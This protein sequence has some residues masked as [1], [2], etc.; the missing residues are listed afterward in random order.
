[1]TDLAGFFAIAIVVIVTPGPDTA[2]TIRNSLLGGRTAGVAVEPV[3]LSPIH[4]MDRV[5][6][7]TLVLRGAN[8]TNCPVVE[9]EQMVDEI[10][11]RGVPVELVLFP[12]EGHGFLKTANRARAAVETVR[13]FERYLG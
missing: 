1:M 7:P 11:R 12:D 5:R 10:G 6:T 13:W 8:D 9:A 4:R 2:L 3:R